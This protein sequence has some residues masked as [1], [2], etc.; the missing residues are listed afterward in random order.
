M[1]FATLAAGCLAYVTYAK[2]SA[3]DDRWIGF[4]NATVGIV[5][6]VPLSRHF[7][8]LDTA[9]LDGECDMLQARQELVSERSLKGLLRRWGIKCGVLALLPLLGAVAGMSTVLM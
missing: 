2:Y 5:G 7:M 9:L 1:P 3:G 6:M 4:A 8:G